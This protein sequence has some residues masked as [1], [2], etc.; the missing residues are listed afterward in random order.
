MSGNLE[1]CSRQ[2]EGQEPGGGA[3]EPEGCPPGRTGGDPGRRGLR[4][5]GLQI[6]QGLESHCWESV[7][8]LR[9]GGGRGSLRSF[10]E[11]N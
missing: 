9:G 3:G 4:H 5:E 2:R 7:F 8:S 6:P 10:E 1:I 11:K